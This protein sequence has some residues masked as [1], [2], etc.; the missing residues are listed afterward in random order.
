M[1]R[2]TISYRWLGIRS[3]AQSQEI[4]F[5]TIEISEWCASAKKCLRTYEF[6][7]VIWNFEVV[8]RAK[9]DDFLPLGISE[10]CASAKKYDL[11]SLFVVSIWCPSVGKYDL[12]PLFVVFEVVS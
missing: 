6:A 8:P 10:W 5:L 11:L 9:K 1:I 2:S 4:R 12:L 3:G 7:A